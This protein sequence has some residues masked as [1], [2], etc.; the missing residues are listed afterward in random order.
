MTIQ[1]KT[2]NKWI[3]QDVSK[4]TTAP[5]SPPFVWC[6]W[7]KFPYNSQ[8]QT[9]NI[10][11]PLILLLVLTR[12]LASHV[13][14]VCAVTRREMDCWD[15]GVRFTAGA[16]L[17]LFS[18]ASRPPLCTDRRVELRLSMFGAIP[19]IHTKP[20]DVFYLNVAL[21]TRVQPRRRSSR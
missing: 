4:Y 7:C 5:S 21:L 15:I 9:Q 14:S 3:V 18:T 19:S 12:K 17:L 13:I 11:Q 1:Q 6:Y 2:G 8:L 10:A 20:N 16:E